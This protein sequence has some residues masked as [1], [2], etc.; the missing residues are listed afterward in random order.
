MNWF[1]RHR[2]QWITETVRVFGFINREH[3]ERKFGV[4]TPQASMDLREYMRMNPGMI[5]Y[6]K[7]AKRYVRSQ[8][9]TGGKQT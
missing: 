1:A 6:D 5:A 2:Q 3:I 8:A 7:T 9:D 4:S